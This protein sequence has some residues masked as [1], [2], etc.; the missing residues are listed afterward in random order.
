MN[1]LRTIR[2]IKGLSQAELAVLVEVTRPLISNIETGRYKPYPKIMAD[3]ERALQVPRED[4][5]PF[6]E[7][8]ES[9]G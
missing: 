4:I 2:R 6:N 5:F 9:N 7:K 8:E 3:C 1:N